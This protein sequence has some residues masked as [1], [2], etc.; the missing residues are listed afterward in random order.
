MVENSGKTLCAD[1]R[2]RRVNMPEPVKVEESAMGVPVAVRTPRK[3][4]VTAVDDCWRIDD[5]WWR[6]EPVS[7]LYYAVRFVSG[8][9]LVIYRDLINGQWYKQAY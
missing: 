2:L 9:R 4:I 1:V 3:Q 8:Q 5:E 6:N 7:R